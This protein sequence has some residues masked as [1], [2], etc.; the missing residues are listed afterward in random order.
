[1]RF[2][3]LISLFS[4][5]ASCR[6]IERQLVTAQEAFSQ[7]NLKV[8]G[9]LFREVAL[10]HPESATAAF[11][12]AQVHAAL[13]EWDLAY[14][15]NRRATALDVN[16][17]EYQHAAL[18]ME[19]AAENWSLA[20]ER[21]HLIEFDTKLKKAK[22]LA[23]IAAG[24]GR[25]EHAVALLLEVSTQSPQVLAIA[26]TN[27]WQGGD[28]V[29]ANELLDRA[30]KYADL[31][32]ALV[33]ANLLIVKNLEPLFLFLNQGNLDTELILIASEFSLRIGAFE[34]SKQFLSSIQSRIPSRIDLSLQWVE[35]LALQGDIE[36]LNRFRELITVEGPRWEGLRDYISGLNSLDENQF[37][38]ARSNLDRAARLLPGRARLD[39][40]LGLLDFR[41]K[42]FDKAKPRL[43]A[44]LN[45][46][47][48]AKRAHL[49]VANIFLEEGRLGD[50]M[51]HA[52]KA[53]AESYPAADMLLAEIYSKLGR[54]Q[55]A[56]E[57]L[58]QSPILPEKS[59]LLLAQLYL[60]Q[61][62]YKAAEAAFLKLTDLPLVNSAAVVGYVDCLIKLDRRE[63]AIEWLADRND[64][65][66]NR[67]AAWLYLQ[68]SQPAAALASIGAASI[69]EED[70]LIRIIAYGK[71]NDLESAIETA[72]GI[73]SPIARL[74][75]AGLLTRNGEFD[76]SLLLY[77]EL[78]TLNPSNTA[79]L[80]GV[81]WSLLQQGRKLNKAKT[82]ARRAHLLMP[83]NKN[84]K[85]TLTSIE[86]FIQEREI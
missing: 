73:E 7:G 45:V 13:G 80:N 44:A 24:L 62:R 85:N 14:A 66:S 40:T 46:I 4:L 26:A 15:F 70:Q 83:E 3:L 20:Q 54:L 51:S 65:Y 75:L 33:M 6:D 68:L 84:Y 57:I 18:Q 43:L 74:V 60:S 37:S 2:F 21:I 63:D 32:K 23:S 64:Q 39:M 52:I 48:N 56:T 36:G 50:A 59:Q 77:D 22:T 61:A 12:R 19:L 58:E 49:A 82:L 10:E 42:D 27:A 16:N 8:S 17:Q 9:E 11:G 29:S 47:P 79:A 38:V 69:D 86:D 71:L 53:Q 41:K 28:L 67:L 72:E 30:M 34:T 76:R 55:Q 1:M 81:A 35:T 78:L 5:L 31:D 25:H